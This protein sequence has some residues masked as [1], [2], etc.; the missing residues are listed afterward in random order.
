MK[1]PSNST[2]K[3]KTTI[4]ERLWRCDAVG[5]S[6]RSSDASDLAAREAE[7]VQVEGNVTS[8]VTIM[9]RTRELVR[10]WMRISRIWWSGRCPWWVTSSRRFEVAIH[11]FS[12]A[13]DCAAQP[14]E[15]ERQLLL[16]IGR[17][18]P[19]TRSELIPVTDQASHCRDEAPAVAGSAGY[20]SR[21]G[22]Q[23]GPKGAWWDEEFPLKR[24]RAEF[25][26]LRLRG[27]CDERPANRRQ[28][29]RRL[30]TLCA[31]AASA[32]DRLSPGQKSPSA[33]GQSARFE[34]PLNDR[35]PTD[36]EADCGTLYPTVLHDATFL[37]AI[38]P[39]ALGQAQRHREPLSLVC[40][41][42]DRLH[43]IRELLGRAAADGLV[44]CVGETVVSLVRKS[45]VVA[46]LDDDR[47]VAVL[48]RSGDEGALRIGQLICQRIAEGRWVFS[49]EPAM[50][51]TVSIGAAT[52][53]T[54]ANSVLSL[55]EAAD[56][57]LAQAQALG[58]NQSVMAAPIPHGPRDA[59][60]SAP[61]AR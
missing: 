59:P 47:I 54:S 57:A 9:K 11:R 52:F 46:R 14:A 16:L 25:G 50:K 13:L 21:G 12:S 10:H 24:G 38:L 33:T 56:A 40:V 27:A 3:P 15:V 29:V 39:F 5:V 2:T 31:L 18:W 36:T 41:A 37:N 30:K 48:Q 49:D 55:F 22:A 17:L 51:I 32:L 61:G 7:R 53:P 6:L 1:S 23:S 20:D 35:E 43:G 8:P 44:R 60:V 45:D 19:E 34:K 26:R 4:S 28:R 58:R 42:I